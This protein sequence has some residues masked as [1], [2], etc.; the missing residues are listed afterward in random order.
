VHLVGFI[1]RIYHDARSSEC[2]LCLSYDT[3]YL[4]MKTGG[5]CACK[6]LFDIRPIYTDCL[7]IERLGTTCQSE[8]SV[9]S[10]S[11]KQHTLGDTDMEPSWD[12][13]I[14]LTVLMFMI[15]QPEHLRNASIYERQLK[16]LTPTQKKR[17]LQAGLVWPWQHSWR[18]VFF[19]S[20]SSARQVFSAVWFWWQ[21][22]YCKHF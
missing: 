9:L 12:C 7:H 6:S 19:S 16:H 5:V 8:N 3:A 11:L 2:Q 15:H 1:I 17:G 13:Q 14:T 22:N 10:F 18:C 21:I 4:F 20:Q